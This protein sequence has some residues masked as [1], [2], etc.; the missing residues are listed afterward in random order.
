MKSRKEINIV[1]AFDRFNYGDL[2]FPKLLEK[3]FGDEFDINFYS[4]TSKNMKPYG[5][6]ETKS[7]LRLYLKLIFKKN[8]NIIV[9]GGHIIGTG[10]YTI[11]S[12][13][14]SLFG[15]QI[16]KKHKSFLMKYTDAI[17]NVIFKTRS[18]YVISI[19]KHNIFYNSVGG[20]VYAGKSKN[21]LI[22]N[23]SSSLLFSVR[24]L[25]L[26][27]ALKESVNKIALVPDSAILMKNYFNKNFSNEE[28]IVFQCHKIDN[29]KT[30][31]IVDQLHQLSEIEK[32]KVILLP[33]G[34][35]YDHEDDNALIKIKNSDK[36]KNN[37]NIKYLELKSVL[38]I[39]NTISGASLFIGTSLHGVITAM[40][41][42]VPYICISPSYKLKEYIF[43][44]D[45]NNFDKN[46]FQFQFIDS[47]KKGGAYFSKEVLDNQISI[48]R[49]NF[50]QI[51]MIL[52]N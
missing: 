15:N 16:V 24:S 34:Y 9:A 51:K 7:I 18:P 6:V 21:E 29:E 11:F 44:W 30:K 49:R 13:N 48:T 10:W 8:Q 52:K 37:D 19:K 22:G 23:L 36:I 5:C 3:V 25:S 28:Y 33:I 50:E 26:Y 14:W 31:L 47:F 12:H 46:P 35:A 4:L 1:G 32:K 40:S 2:L 38:G 41:F 17:L 39:M 45:R 42:S 43:D 27:H 20:K